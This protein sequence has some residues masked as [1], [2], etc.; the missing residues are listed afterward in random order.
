MS[1]GSKIPQKKGSWQCHLT[2]NL[3]WRRQMGGGYDLPPTE[4]QKKTP[5]PSRGHGIMEQPGSE[6]TA[7]RQ[8]WEDKCLL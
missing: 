4:Y 7:Q 5:R 3:E 1:R 8:V 6:I 2:V